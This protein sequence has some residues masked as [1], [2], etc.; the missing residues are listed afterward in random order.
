MVCQSS[1]RLSS[2]FLNVFLCSQTNFKS[3]VFYFIVV[4]SACSS[5]LLTLYAFALPKEV[6]SAQVYGFSQSHRIR[7]ISWVCS[8]VMCRLTLTIHTLKGIHREAARWWGCIWVRCMELEVPMGQLERPGRR[9]PQ[10]LMAELPDESPKQLVGSMSLWYVP[11][12]TMAAVVPARLP[13]PKHFA[14]Q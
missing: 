6:M 14:T 13:A 3:S 12:P 8:L 2:L 4:S 5:L 1:H 9:H 10:W 7:L 11:F